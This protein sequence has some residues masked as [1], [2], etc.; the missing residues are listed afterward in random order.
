MTTQFTAIVEQGRLRPAVPMELAEGTVVEV[1]VVSSST[2]PACAS[3]AEILSAI[4]ALPADTVDPKTSV[5]HDEILYGR[6][7][8]P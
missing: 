8:H 7:A 1:F 4:A 5:R 6:G 3:P 2:A